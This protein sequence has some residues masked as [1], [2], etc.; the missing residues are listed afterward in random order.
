MPSTSSVLRGAES[1]AARAREFNDS[2]AAYQYDNSTKTYADYVSYEQYLRSQQSAATSPT[3][4]LTYQKKIESARTS[5]ISNEV[6]RQSINVIEGNATNIEKYNRILDLYYW[7]LDN[8]QNDLAQSMRLQLDN[9]S[10]TIQNEQKAAL[11]ANKETANEV[12]K[13]IDVQVKDAVTQIEDNA[14]YVLEQYQLM[15]PQAFEEATGSDLFSMLANM[16]N[17]QDPNNPG[18]VQ[19]YDQAMQ[20]TPDA[21]KVRDYQTKFNDLANG[22]ST[23]IELPGAGKLTYKDIIDQAY[24]QSIGQTLFEAVQTADGTQFS[25]NQE[26]GYA[27]GRDENGQ[28]KLMPIYNPKQ[29]FKS[30]V[31]DPNRSNQ[32][33]SYDTVLDNA[34]FEVVRKGDNSLIVRNNGEFDAAGIPRGQQV[35]LYVDAKGNLQVVNGNSAYSLGFDN[36]SGKFTGLSA[37]APNPINLVGDRFNRRFFAGQDLSNVAA[38]T[39]GLVDTQSPFARLMESGPL[40][41]QHA[42]IQGVNTPIPKPVAPSAVQGGAVDP[43]GL[44]ANTVLTV[45]KPQ[46]MPKITVAKPKPLPALGKTVNAIPETYNLKAVNAVPETS[47]LTVGNSFYDPLQNLTF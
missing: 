30:G 20:A 33:L 1:A 13:A 19:V 39:I 6:Q 37:Q 42:A 7:T 5:Y 27:W 16:I 36:R 29:S 9:L 47:L 32:T 24:A 28:Y 45:A 22:G 23:G 3:S 12:S 25:R 40:G 15:G 8:G 21:G 14:K 2:L 26:T 10:V 31:A 35:Q 4:Q 17:S 38:G 18:L 11:A 46:P 43:H 41:V 34:G 44:P